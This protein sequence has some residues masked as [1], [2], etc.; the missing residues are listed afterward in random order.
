MKLMFMLS[1]LGLMAAASDTPAAAKAGA[2]D[3]AAAKAAE[4]K[5]AAEKAAAEKEAAEKEAAAKKAAKKKLR[6]RCLIPSLGEGDDTY[7][8]GDEFETTP[9]RAE[10]LGDLVEPVK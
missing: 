8:K 1:A 2:D 5:A 4:K 10:A 9:E 6:V 7:S 3:L